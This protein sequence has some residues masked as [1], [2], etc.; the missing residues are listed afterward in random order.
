M[1]VPDELH[2]MLYT[3]ALYIAAYIDE[4]LTR[5]NRPGPDKDELEAMCLM[6]ADA[7]IGGAE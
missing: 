7:F 2:H 4:E 5:Q 6:A 1:E 3:A